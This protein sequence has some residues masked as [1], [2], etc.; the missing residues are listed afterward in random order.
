MK[1]KTANPAVVNKAETEPQHRT[2]ADIEEEKKQWRI[3]SREARSRVHDLR[4]ELESYRD[5]IEAVPFDIASGDMNPPGC[6]DGAERQ[7]ALGLVENLNPVVD[8]LFQL[9]DSVAEKHGAREEMDFNQQLFELKMH[10]ADTGF[11]IGVLA[12]AMFSGASKET[13]DRFERGFGVRAR[14]KS[15]DC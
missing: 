1:K 6:L 2:W 12:G 14:L 8:R 13:V 11:Y 15:M 10:A 9:C 4:T 3:T 7:F 5:Q